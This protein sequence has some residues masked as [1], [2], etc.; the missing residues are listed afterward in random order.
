L[1]KGS[2]IGPAKRWKPKPRWKEKGTRTF[3]PSTYFFSRFLAVS[4]LVIIMIGATVLTLAT[5]EIA[6]ALIPLA[7]GLLLAAFVGYGRWRLSPLST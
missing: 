2:T 4:G 1:P 6:M 5:G 3:F 7:V